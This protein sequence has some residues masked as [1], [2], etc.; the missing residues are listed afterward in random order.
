MHEKCFCY[1]S[2]VYRVG[3]SKVLEKNRRKHAQKR[4]ASTLT[5]NFNLCLQDRTSVRQ[6]LIL[7]KLSLLYKSNHPFLQEESLRRRTKRQA[8]FP[9]DD[10]DIVKLDDGSGDYENT[11]VVEN[12]PM[13]SEPVSSSIDWGNLFDSLVK[14]IVKTD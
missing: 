7:H 6:E 14:S 2:N 5:Q 3:F 8:S 13:T 12:Y 9:S 10:E 11:S 4:I 1:F